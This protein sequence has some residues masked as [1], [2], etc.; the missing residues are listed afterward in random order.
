SIIAPFPGSD[1]SYFKK[2]QKRSFVFRPIF[3][4]KGWFS[5]YRHV[6]GDIFK[7]RDYRQNYYSTLNSAIFETT[8]LMMDNYYG[9]WDSIGKAHW[10]MEG[11]S[12]TSNANPVQAVQ[13]YL[14]SGNDS[15]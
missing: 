3:S 7:L 5:A 2:G 10:N 1:S 9:G 14:L 13:S 15:I 11:R 4:T 8:K 12:F 6:V